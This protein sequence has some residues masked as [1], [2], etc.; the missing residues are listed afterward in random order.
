V[1]SEDITFYLASIWNRL[2]KCNDEV[3]RDYQN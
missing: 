1:K 3:K 2:D